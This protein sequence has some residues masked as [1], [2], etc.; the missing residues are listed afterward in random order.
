MKSI[1]IILLFAIFILLNGCSPKP[2]IMYRL[3]DIPKTEKSQF[4]SS[5]LAIAEFKDISQKLKEQE[6]F[7][8]SH[9][10]TILRNGDNM[11]WFFNDPYFYR[12]KKIAPWVTEMIIKHFNQIGLFKTTKLLNS[13]SDTNYDYIL[14]GS[15]QKF[16]G[17]KKGSIA[18]GQ[19]GAIFDYMIKTR[20]EGITVFI[21]IK[22]KKRDNGKVLW[23]GSVEG[24]I[25]GEDSIDRAGWSAYDKANESLKIAV[26]QLIE[27]LKGLSVN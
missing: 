15:I 18:A 12:N 10:R 7:W 8:T 13:V 4:V 6:L 23:S 25:E 22:L 5:T 1:R 3:N 26:N 20:Y 27:K 2:H 9:H 21:D 14:E 17:Y 24:K 11:Y 16:E 19:F